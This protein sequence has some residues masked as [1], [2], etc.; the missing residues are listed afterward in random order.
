M[1]HLPEMVFDKNCLHLE[2]QGGFGIAFNALDALRLVDDKHDSLKVAEAD[3][4]LA[5]R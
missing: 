1:P 5:A 4:W 3:E 2:H